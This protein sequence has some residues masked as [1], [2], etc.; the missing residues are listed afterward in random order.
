MIAADADEASLG[1]LVCSGVTA[2]V[3]P[4]ELFCSKTLAAIL[5]REGALSR[6]QTSMDFKIDLLIKCLLAIVTGVSFPYRAF[7]V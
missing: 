4:Q 5:A 1:W 3:P 7:L 6:V 2:H